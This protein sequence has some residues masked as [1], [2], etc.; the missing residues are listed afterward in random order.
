MREL[1]VRTRIRGML[2]RL[3]YWPIT[4]TDATKTKCDKCGNWVMAYPPK[5][6]PDI[7][8]LHPRGLNIVVEVKAIFPDETS[9]QF[10]KINEDQRDWLDLWAKDKGHGY[11]GLGVITKTGSKDRLDSIYLVDWK[12][13]LEM[14]AK[15]RP[16]QASVPL[17]WERARFLAIKDGK[18]DIRRLLK[19]WKLT[20]DKKHRWVLPAGHTAHPTII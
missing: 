5:G 12:N 6:R 10:S 17:D 19:S 2:W 14:E 7:L 11:L 3:G 18:L 4:Q 13:W 16:I 20:Q 9:F 8:V 15:L 1:E